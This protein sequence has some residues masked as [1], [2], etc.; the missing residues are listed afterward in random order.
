MKRS[1]LIKEVLQLQ[2]ELGI[3]RNTDY[4]FSFTNSKLKFLISSF[5]DKI[6]NQEESQD[7]RI[8]RAL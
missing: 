1:E 4:Y 8:Y 7:Y 3:K 2:K 6:D 5:Q